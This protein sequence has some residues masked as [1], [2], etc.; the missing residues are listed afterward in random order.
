MKDPAEALHGGV[1]H[2]GLAE[3]GKPEGSPQGGLHLREMPG[4]E[5]QAAE[6]NGSWAVLLRPYCVRQV[7]DVDSHGAGHRAQA[8]PGAGL[9]PKV[10]IFLAE[11]LESAD[12]FGG[13]LLQGFQPGYLPSR[14]YPGARREGEAARDAVDLA[15]TA[16]DAF[17]QARTV[18]KERQGLEVPEMARRVVVEYHP[19]IE[20]PFRVEGGL[21][22]LHDPE[23]LVPPFIFNIGGH[24]PARPVLRLEGAVVAADHHPRHVVD[25][26]SVAGHL[27]RGVEGLVDDEMEVAL[28]GM[29]VDAGVV[30][31]VP[32]QKGGQV[33]DSIGQVL[34]VECHVLDQ[35]GGPLPSQPAHGREYSR[36]EGPE[37]GALRRVGGE[38]DFPEGVA[39]SKHSLYPG[40]VFLQGRLRERRRAGEDGRHVGTGI[41]P[42]HGV[43]Y[44]LER[45]AVEQFSGTDHL[46]AKGR[47]HRHHR[48]GSLPDRREIDHGI[49]LVRLLGKGP[50]GDAAHEGE[51]AFRPGEQVGDDLERVGEPDERQQ[52][53]ACHILD[54]IL[55]LYPFH[56]RLVLEYPRTD[57]QDGVQDV[58]T[59]LAEVLPGSFILGV[60]DGPVGEDHP[61][62]DHQHV[63]VGMGAAAHPGGIVH[64]DPSDHAA[65]DGRRV[66]AEPAAVGLEQLPHPC[67]DEA[68]PEGY[69]GR[70][71]TRAEGF[72]T[73]SGNNQHRV[74]DALAGEAGASRPESHGNLEP[75]CQ[76][77]D[78]GDFPFVPG[79]DDYLRGEAVET[80]IGPPGKPPEGI[81]QQPVVGDEGACLLEENGVTLVHGRMTIF[82]AI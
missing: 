41:L 53:Q 57:P 79:K 39:A 14:R 50:H 40:Y 29:A 13:R 75:G 81:G 2:D 22:F 32:V 5:G 38:T 47:L 19:G 11:G 28:Q 56:E 61:G 20:D 36:T 67:P 12:L 6:G 65:S 16:F 80:C 1:P 10:G 72:P 76:S 52:V 21:D 3:G 55:V 31:A 48:L 70:V 82:P 18:G 63:R 62:P 58:R 45:P 42:E 49:R 71:R 8:V 60:Q 33:L 44:R 54:G 51:R 78:A 23:S 24:V 9:L 69:R 4:S 35:A 68:G 25:H 77:K 73:L 66:W 26:G 30:V 7:G 27:L 59:G 64:H 43:S 34:D 15:E 74:A 46:Q 37:A 17:V